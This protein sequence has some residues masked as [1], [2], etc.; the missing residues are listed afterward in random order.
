MLEGAV[1]RGFLGQR[2]VLANWSNFRAKKMHVFLSSQIPSQNLG[3][4]A[5]SSRKEEE[6]SLCPTTGA[7]RR[8]GTSTWS[9]GQVSSSLHVYHMGATW[10]PTRPEKG[11]RCPETRVRPKCT[12]LPSSVDWPRPSAGV[13]SVLDHWATC[14]AQML[15]CWRGQLAYLKYVCAPAGVPLLSVP[16]VFNT[17]HASHI[18]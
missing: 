9:L 15:T 6:L 5:A 11:V 18:G 12:M 10:F 2:R 16:Q 13:T 17:K 3:Q 14:L 1:I 7:R 8:K 4:E